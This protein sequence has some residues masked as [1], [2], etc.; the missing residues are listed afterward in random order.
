MTGV[1]SISLDGDE[2]KELILNSD[3][4]K[5][6][7]LGETFSSDEITILENNGEEGLKFKISI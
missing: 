1:F 3:L 7:D 2:F 5:K 4:V 6:F